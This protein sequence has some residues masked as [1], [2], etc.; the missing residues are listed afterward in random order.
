[1]KRVI[2]F[3]LVLLFS[4]IVLVAQSA[5]AVQAPASPDTGSTAEGKYTN[6]YFGF[7]ISLPQD[8]SLHSESL[9][10]NDPRKKFLFGLKGQDHGFAS[11]IVT[12]VVADSASS[13]DAKRE[14]SDAKAG[15]PN[16]VR[17]A[18]KDFWRSEYLDKSPSG[19]MQSVEYATPLG[20]Y[21]L[22]FAIFSFDPKVTAEFEHTVE[23]LTFFEPAKGKEKGGAG[24]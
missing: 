2:P 15:P 9:P 19:K 22:K 13:D 8:T 24:N 12:A 21:V 10:Y 1:M 23:S 20:S 16:R 7:T 4:S 14:V 6:T 3:T 5:L 18:G 11:F 17:I